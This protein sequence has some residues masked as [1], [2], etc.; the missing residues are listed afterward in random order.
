MAEAWII[1]EPQS[2]RRYTNA[3]L[4]LMDQ[5]MLDHAVIV[6]D[7][8][9]WMSEDEVREFCQARL[10]DDDN[11][12][13]IREEEEVEEEQDPLDDFNYVGSRHHY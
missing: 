2:S 10:R 7:L 5:G 8:V 9:R 12:C 1:V 11:E 4:K 13:V 3:L 6:E